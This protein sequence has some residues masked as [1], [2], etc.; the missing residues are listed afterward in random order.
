MA[1]E[2]AAPIGA[3]IDEV[4]IFDAH[5]HYKEEAW[6]R[7]PVATVILGGLVTSTFCEFLIHPGIFWRFSGSAAVE[8]A[9]RDDHADGLDEPNLPHGAADSGS[10]AQP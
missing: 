6:A 2:T 7:Y 1:D 4:P 8:L 5:M 3:A 9:R 10:T